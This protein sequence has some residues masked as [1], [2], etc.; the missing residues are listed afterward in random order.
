M[1]RLPALEELFFNILVAGY[2][3][4]LTHPERLSWIKSH[5]QA[6]QRLVQ[7]GVWIQLT[8]GS[9]A[10]AFGRN[11]RYWAERMLDEGC[12]HILATDAHDVDRRPPNLSQGGA[13][14]EAGR[15]YEAEHMVVTRPLGM[16]RNE[17]PSNLCGPKTALSLTRDG[18]LAGA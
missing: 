17:L 2:V 9:L 4:I 1:S 5:Y 11:A 15:Q 3:P 10:G 16:L 12:V 14:V 7:A 18:A 8:A 13:R 6:I